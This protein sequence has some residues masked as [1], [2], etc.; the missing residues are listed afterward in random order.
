MILGRVMEGLQERLREIIE[1]LFFC[2]GLGFQMY[3]G[4]DRHIYA[5][6]SR[7]I[8]KFWLGDLFLACFQKQL[9]RQITIP[10]LWAGCLVATCDTFQ[11]FPE[12][13]E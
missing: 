7:K 1:G 5:L 9:F 8:V 10:L 4:M 11:Q 3:D 13:R 12:A 6:C 2:D